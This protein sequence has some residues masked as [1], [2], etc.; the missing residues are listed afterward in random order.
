MARI[1]GK[2]LTSEEM[3]KFLCQ[4]LYFQYMHDEYPNLSF[5]NIEFKLVNEYNI[6]KNVYFT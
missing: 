6:K 3:E 2:K 1:K 5:N 4:K